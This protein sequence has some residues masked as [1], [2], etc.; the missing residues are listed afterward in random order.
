MKVDQYC[1]SCF[2]P[3][4]HPEFL[5]TEADGSY[6]YEYCRHCYQNGMFTNPFAALKEMQ[7]CGRHKMGHHHED[8]KSILNG[9]TSCPK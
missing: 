3:L 7:A 6:N 2:M 8:A 1:Q 9:S 5:G 4:D